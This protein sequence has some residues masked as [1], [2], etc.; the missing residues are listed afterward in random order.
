MWIKTRV[1]L[2]AIH[3]DIEIRV[4]KYDKTKTWGL[5]AHV[6]SGSEAEGKSLFGKIKFGGAWF[7][8][9]YF[10]DHPDVQLEIGKAMQAI[11]DSIASNSTICD[12]SQVGT[13]EAWDKAWSQIKWP[14]T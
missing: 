14:K 12:L 9:A 8:L 10:V 5:Y 6:R 3:N 2:C 4:H 1:G 11:V 13:S 7:Q